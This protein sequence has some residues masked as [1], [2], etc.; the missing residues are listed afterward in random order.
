MSQ[1]TEQIVRYTP[2][3]WH[4]SSTGTDV[5][6]PPR[7]PNTTGAKARVIAVMSNAAFAEC[8]ANAHLIAAA[9]DLYA[10][11]K[12]FLSADEPTDA[13][14]EIEMAEAALRKAEGR[15]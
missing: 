10:A 3:P 2:G 6:G 9:P 8:E 13:A 11:L 5:I 1:S 15:A 14:A 12:R 7:V 4:V